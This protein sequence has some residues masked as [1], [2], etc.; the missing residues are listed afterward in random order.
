MVWF[1][2]YGGGQSESVVRHVRVKK[3]RKDTRLP[4]GIRF[5]LLMCCHL[6]SPANMEINHTHGFQGSFSPSPKPPQHTLICITS[7]KDITAKTLYQRFTDIHLFSIVTHLLSCAN[8]CSE[9]S[10]H[11]FSDLLLHNI[12]FCGM[13]CLA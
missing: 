6:N 10:Q 8:S 7:V 1:F 9:C 2:S 3:L 12:R 5:I 13:F 11:V 4:L